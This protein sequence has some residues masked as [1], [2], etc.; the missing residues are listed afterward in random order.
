MSV[1]NLF[2]AR[3]NPRQPVVGLDFDGVLWPLGKSGRT[4]RQRGELVQRICDAT[5][6][7]VLLTTGWI[8]PSPGETRDQAIA[9]CIGIL[10]RSGIT[11]PVVGALAD[12][13]QNELGMRGDRRSGR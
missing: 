10:R 13:G 2:F 8:E 4:C 9:A 11:A 7:G 3:L 12:S 6:A 5:G 1:D